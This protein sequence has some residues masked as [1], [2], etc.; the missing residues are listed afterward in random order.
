M[1]VFRGVAAAHISSDE[2]F[3]RALFVQMH[4]CPAH[5]QVVPRLYVRLMDPTEYPSTVEVEV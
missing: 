2:F 1:Q 3:L 4:P 5:G